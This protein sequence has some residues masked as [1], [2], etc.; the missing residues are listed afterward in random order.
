MRF[1][2]H[3]FIIYVSTGTSSYRD[4]CG[5]GRNQKGD[6]YGHSLVIQ[7]QKL[8]DDLAD[9]TAEMVRAFGHRDEV[10]STVE[11]L[12]NTCQSNLAELQGARRGIEVRLKHA[13]CWGVEA[14]QG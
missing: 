9:R 11:D 10:E 1:S 4:S 7:V 13:G 12:R 2:C 8:R 3:L 5:R 14:V 6:A